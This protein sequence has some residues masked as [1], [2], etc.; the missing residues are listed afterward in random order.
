[1]ILQ[2]KLFALLFAYLETLF[3]WN[4]ERVEAIGLEQRFLFVD[5]HPLI[6]TPDTV[7]SDVK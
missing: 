7:V 4:E 5:N 3:N 1:M 2:K 6:K